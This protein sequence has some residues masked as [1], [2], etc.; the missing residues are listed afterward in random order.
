[1]ATRIG[2]L[3][4]QGAFSEHVTSLEQAGAETAE[5]RLPS[6]LGTIDG[7][8][9]PGGESTSISL[10]MSEY[11]MFDPICELARQGFPIW[12]TCA[13]LIMLS[14][15]SSHFYPRTLGVMDVKVERNAYGRQLDSFEAD[16]EIPA[17]G[18]Q[19]YRG[20][21]IRAPKIAGVGPD[22]QVLC[23]QPGNVPVAVRQG[24]LLSCS[25]HPELSGD[26]RFHRY[27][28]EIVRGRQIARTGNTC[29]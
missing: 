5:I 27:F 20:I 29:Q 11:R 19:P 28:L 1:M 16:L 14:S 7:L 3:A 9:I 10:L 26:I 24:N 6:G 22:V 12:G 8:V 15:L 25:F 23:R 4:L 18:V 17:L 2:V 21:F 13:G